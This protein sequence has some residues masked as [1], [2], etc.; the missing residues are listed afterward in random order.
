MN[1]TI[2]DLC[3]NDIAYCVY[4]DGNTTILNVIDI[5]V[6]K[7]NVAKNKITFAKYFNRYT[8]VLSSDANNSCICD[9]IDG[10]KVTILLTKKDALEELQYIIGRCNEGINLINNF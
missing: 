1:K 8:F 10:N 7:Q 6:D 9:E 3:I 4:E 5:Q 2:K